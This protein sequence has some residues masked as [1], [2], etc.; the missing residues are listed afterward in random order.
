MTGHCGPI[1]A[2]WGNDSESKC[3]K[4]AVG[5]FRPGIAQA[6]VGAVDGQRN[7]GAQSGI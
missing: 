2:R 3:R 6:A 7:S 1:A 5:G 4:S